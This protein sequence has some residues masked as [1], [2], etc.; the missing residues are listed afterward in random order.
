[1]STTFQES[2]MT[3]ARTAAPVADRLSAKRAAHER[4]RDRVRLS[5]LVSRREDPATDRRRP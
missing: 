4:Q 3:P 1:M 5:L 2:P